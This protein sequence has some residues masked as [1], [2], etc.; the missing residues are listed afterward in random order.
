MP[1]LLLPGFLLP[2]PMGAC[3][4]LGILWGFLCLAG[5]FR[6]SADAKCSGEAKTCSSVPSRE[7]GW[8]SLKTTKS[9]SAALG[10]WEERNAEGAGEEREGRRQGRSRTSPSPR[11]LRCKRTKLLELRASPGDAG[12][13]GVPR[14][15]AQAVCPG[16]VPRLR[17]LPQPSSA[18]SL[19]LLLCVGGR[20]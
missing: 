3:R 15:R 13:A 5:G 9:C 17:A 20:C 10:S 11:E 4:G 7:L 1:C 2:S 18:V 19:L 6:G 14:L 12:S 16:C 8:R